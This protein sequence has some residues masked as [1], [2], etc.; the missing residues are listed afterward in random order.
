LKRL[1]NTPRICKLIHDGVPEA[2]RGQN[3][4]A[5][6]RVGAGRSQAS[7]GTTRTQGE[8]SQDLEE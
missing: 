4:D 6:P 5:D 2:E 8:R 7:K 1:Y 3:L